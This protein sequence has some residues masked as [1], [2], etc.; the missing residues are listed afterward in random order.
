VKFESW[1]AAKQPNEDGL[2][3]QARAGKI[4]EFRRKADIPPMRSQ[5]AGKR[6]AFASEKRRACVTKSL[7]LR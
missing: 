4:V 6:L 7:K 1:L 2:P 3:H 5:Y